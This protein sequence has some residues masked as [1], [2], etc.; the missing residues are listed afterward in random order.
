MLQTLARFT[1]MEFNRGA[2]ETNEKKTGKPA[3]LF[4]HRRSGKIFENIMICVVV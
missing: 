1:V 4:L 2:Q 3:L